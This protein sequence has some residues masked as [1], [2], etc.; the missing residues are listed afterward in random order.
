MVKNSRAMVGAALA[1]AVMVVVTGCG[2]RTEVTAAA[3]APT[4]GPPG[5]AAAASPGSIDAFRAAVNDAPYLDGTKR[6]P[7]GGVDRL[8]PAGGWMIRGRVSR[9]ERADRVPD[10]RADPDG[11]EPL[12]LYGIDLVISPDRSAR[13]TGVPTGPAGELRVNLPLLTAQASQDLSG[14]RY[15]QLERALQ[16]APVGA[17]AIVVGSAGSVVGSRVRG[18]GAGQVVLAPQGSP[19]VVAVDRA[20]A[21]AVRGLSIDALEAEVVAAVQR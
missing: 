12:L 10:L 9:V 13:A 14:V 18:A 7:A 16:Q 19:A 17:D 20:N 15:P 5:I 1:S 11:R 21:A 8:V 6:I 2:A 4:A 3:P